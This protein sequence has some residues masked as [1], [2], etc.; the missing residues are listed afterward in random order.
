MATD[1]LHSLAGEQTGNQHLGGTPALDILSSVAALL[2]HG[3]WAL[4]FE[5]TAY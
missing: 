2:T 3:Y 4:Y 5:V 1:V